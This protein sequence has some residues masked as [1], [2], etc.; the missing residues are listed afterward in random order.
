VSAGK[1][2][3]GKTTYHITEMGYPKPLQTSAYFTNAEKVANEEPFKSKYSDN[4]AQVKLN[5]N[6]DDV[7]ISDL[8]AAGT[9]FH[10]V[11]HTKMSMNGTGGKDNDSQH[12]GMTLDS[13]FQ[14]KMSFMTEFAGRE[15]TQNE[16]VFHQWHGLA[17]TVEYAEQFMNKVTDSNGNVRYEGYNEKGKAYLNSI[18][19]VN[20]RT[21]IEN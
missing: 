19:K 18:S 3:Y 21:G 4:H 1:A 16:Q 7:G 12:N 10:E 14:E 8:A 2:E 6:L 13:Y 11:W 5:N 9:L 20:D 15:L 17:G